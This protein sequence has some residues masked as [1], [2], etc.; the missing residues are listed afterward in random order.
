METAARCGGN[1]NFDFEN[2]DLRIE[3]CEGPT[4]L[5]KISLDSAGCATLKGFHILAVA[6]FFG[7][8]E[9]RDLIFGPFILYFT[10]QKSLLQVLDF[11]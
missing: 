9:S 1:S 2:I 6:S 8:L 5:E 10:D 3:P 11:I 4:L 7:P